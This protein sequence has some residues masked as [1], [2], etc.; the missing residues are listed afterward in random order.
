MREGFLSGT[1]EIVIQCVFF[2]LMLLAVEVGFRLGRRAESSTK[3]A[4]KSQIAIVEAALL[5]ILALLLGFTMSM[6]VSRFDARKQLVLAEANAIGT[7]YLRTR[8]LPAPDGP[9]IA[10]LL[11]QYIQVRVQYGNSGDGLAPLDDLHTQTTHLQTEIWTR[12]AAYAQKDPNPVK[13][14]LLLQSLNE[15]I[16]METARWTAVQNHVPPNVIYINAIVALLASMLVGYAYG[17]DGRRNPFSMCVLV[18]AITMV[19]AVI[20]DLDRPRSGFIRA[21]QQPMTDLL[22]QY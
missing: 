12:A 6:A 13:A 17:L 22:N 2:A 18:L 11:R 5:G 7:S 16:D 14:G 20:V 3:P 21:S 8:L 4:T 10:S 15:A 9:E 1:H 19:L